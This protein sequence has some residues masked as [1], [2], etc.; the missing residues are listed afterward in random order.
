M[1]QG[2]VLVDK[3]KYK[4]WKDI[5]RS[6]SQDVKLKEGTDL[7]Q[8]YKDHAFS[9]NEGRELRTKALYY[10][11]LMLLRTQDYVKLA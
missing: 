10:L 7:A 3:L 1:M 5:Y 8:W 2:G 9:T 11:V 4:E 6:L